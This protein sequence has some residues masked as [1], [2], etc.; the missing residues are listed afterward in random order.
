MWRSDHLKK[1]RII[2]SYALVLLKL[3]AQRARL[4]GREILFYLCPLTPPSRRGLRG[5]YRLGKFIIFLASF[6]FA[7]SL[8]NSPA[9]LTIL[10]TNSALLLARTPLE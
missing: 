7:T 6:A 4:P 10:S 9:I 5:T 1:R 3:A 8:P 2:I